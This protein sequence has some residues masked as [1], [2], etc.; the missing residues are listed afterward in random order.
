MGF[1]V[2]QYNEKIT[3][4]NFSAMKSRI[5]LANVMGQGDIED[6]KKLV[7][8]QDPLK[9]HAFLKF[10]FDADLL[11]EHVRSGWMEIYDY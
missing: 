2:I 7:N 5:H 11:R 10:A 3:V 8:S 9:L 6:Y 4:C 1:L